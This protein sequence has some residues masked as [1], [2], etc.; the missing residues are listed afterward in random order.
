LDEQPFP[1]PVKLE[2][3]RRNPEGYDFMGVFTM[4]PAC[5]NFLRIGFGTRAKRFLM[6]VGYDA[7]VVLGDR[8]KRS[9]KGRSGIARQ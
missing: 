7:T 5:L 2:S 9:F 3:S 4:A 8:L 6:S 1:I